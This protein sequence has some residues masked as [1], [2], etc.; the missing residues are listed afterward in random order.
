MSWYGPESLGGNVVETSTVAWQADRL[1]IFATIAGA[2]LQHWWFDNGWG[3]NAQP[4]SLGGELAGFGGLSAVSWQ[5]GRLDVFGVANNGTLQ[6]WW[7][8]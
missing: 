8:F 3:N 6:H 1:D 7:Y 2:P 5:P 4:E